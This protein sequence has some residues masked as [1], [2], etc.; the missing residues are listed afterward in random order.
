MQR[1]RASGNGRRQKSDDLRK[2][3]AWSRRLGLPQELSD[4]RRRLLDEVRHR[5]AI[6]RNIYVH[7]EGRHPAKIRPKKRLYSVRRG[8]GGSP[9]LAGASSSSARFRARWRTKR[10]RVHSAHWKQ[11]AP[12]LCNTAQRLRHAA[13]RAGAPAPLANHG[14]PRRHS[15]ANPRAGCPVFAASCRPHICPL[16]VLPQVPVAQLG[17]VARS[18]APASR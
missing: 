13:L 12:A 4:Q 8:T 10:A 16:F 18:A 11:E 3:K 2:S 15:G 17:R 5:Q 14:K 1:C 7:Y 9:C 6:S